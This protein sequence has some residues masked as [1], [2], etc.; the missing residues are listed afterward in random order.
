[1]SSCFALRDVNILK[2]ES[3]PATTAMRLMSSVTD[4]TYHWDMIFYIDYDTTAIE[5]RVKDALINNLKEFSLWVRVLGCYN[6]SIPHS[7]AKASEWK[8]TQ[9]LLIC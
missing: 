8:R 9:D 5:E 3:R 6:S 1:M 4:S 7:Q 2:I